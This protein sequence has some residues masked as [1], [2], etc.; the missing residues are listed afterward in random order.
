MGDLL[1]PWHLMVL[2]CIFS[3]FFL[4]PAIFYL[5]TLQKTLSQCAP[6]S[7]TMEPGMVWLL[8]VP[9]VNLVFNF[10]VVLAIAKSLANEF[11]RR[12][13]PSPEPQPGQPLGI[14]MCICACCVI[15]PL[16]GFFVGI[17]HLVLWI[18]YWVKIADYSRR[19]A[20]FPGTAQA[21]IG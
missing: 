17:A 13:I 20:V 19:L 2:F 7:R 12:G 11:A 6:V 8:L 21:P 10:F 15:V 9:L 1:Q 5:L 14:A 3:L 18:V 16:L 4:V